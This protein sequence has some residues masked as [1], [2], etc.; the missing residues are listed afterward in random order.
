[1]ESHGRSQ[2]DL[3]QKAGVDNIDDFT[4][5]LSKRIHRKLH[6]GKGLGKG[7]VYNFLWRKFND[8]KNIAKRTPEDIKRFGEQLKKFFGTDKIDEIPYRK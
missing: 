1:M 7:G 6:S 8:D 2:R 4:Q 3:F 5:K